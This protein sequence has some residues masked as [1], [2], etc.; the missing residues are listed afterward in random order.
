[1]SEIKNIVNGPVIPTP[2]AVMAASKLLKDEIGDLITVDVGGATTDIHS[3]TAGSERIN[4][5]LLAPETYS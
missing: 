2:G 4:K 3:V 5:I 1:M